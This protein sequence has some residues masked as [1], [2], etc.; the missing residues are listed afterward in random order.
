TRPGDLRFE[1]QNSDGVINED[2]RV[3]IGD[4]NPR[5]MFGMNLSASWRSFDAGAFLQGVGKRDQYLALGFIQG[6]VW[7]NYTSV[8]HNSYYDP[9]LDNQD[10]R[11]PTWYANENRNYY[12][13]SS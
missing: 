9:A 7:E 10:A 13:T 6:P 1:D 12:T 2:D 3:I 11:H 5:Y 8:W 4:P